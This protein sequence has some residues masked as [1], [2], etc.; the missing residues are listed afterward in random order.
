MLYVSLFFALIVWGA[1]LHAARR[2]PHPI[3]WG[4]FGTVGA[5]AMLAPFL[6]LG[7]PVVAGVFGLLVVALLIWQGVR[8]RL[9]TFL[10][11]SLVAVAI[12]FGLVGR[13]AVQKAAVY[14]KLREEYPFESLADRLPEPRAALRTPPASAA[15]QERFDWFEQKVESEAREWTFRANNL[16]RLHERSVN[17]F[18]NSPGFGAVRMMRDG[19]SKTTLAE[20]R[21]RGETP[22]QPGSPAAWGHAEPFEPILVADRE[23]L[24]ALHTDGTLDFVN[25]QGWGYVKDR[26]RVAGFLSHRFSKVPEAK[27]WRVQRIELVGL[28]KHPEPVVYL[29]DRLPAMAELRDTLTRP[30]DEFESAGVEAVRKGEDSF[31]ARRGEVVRFVG[32]IRSAKQCV[33]CHGGARGD[34]LGAFAY[35]LRPSGERP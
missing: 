9:R 32:G 13:E 24:G 1:A 26:T 16:Q 23:Q 14:D 33:E 2:A 25:P 22:T 30:L 21:D 18:V 31:A 4:E 27:T 29:S 15:A 10:P 11:L 8:T 6:C 12:P 3:R 20:R 28:L 35:T 7:S 34:L 19:I 17:T 5:G